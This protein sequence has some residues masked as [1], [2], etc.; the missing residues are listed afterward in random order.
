MPIKHAETIS[1]SI[2]KPFDKVYSYLAIP[3]NYPQWAS[4]L[5]K[6]LKKWG[7]IYMAETNDG[8]MKVKFS[9][10]ND[11]GIADHFV[12]PSTEIEIYIPL[13]VI[14][15]S[16]GSEVLLTLF[17]EPG[18]TDETFA[19]DAEWVRKDLKTLKTILEKA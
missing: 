5:A 9:E 14:K 1:V 11:F 13:R 10:K 7:H 6:G 18:M 2:Q 17:Q 12:Y 8:M 19:A 4:G 3:E 16:E 15:N